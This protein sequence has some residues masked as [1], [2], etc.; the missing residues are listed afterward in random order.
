MKGTLIKNQSGWVVFYEVAD[1]EQGI[2]W[3]KQ[4]PLYPDTDSE[5]LKNGE[6]IEFEVTCEFTHPK[7]YDGIGWG[8]GTLYAKLLAIL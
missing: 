1:L 5:N 6:E 8:D 7:L 2:V 4:L 3:E